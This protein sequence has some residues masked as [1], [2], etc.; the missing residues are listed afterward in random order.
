MGPLYHPVE[1]NLIR[2]ILNVFIAD[3]SLS[4]WWNETFHR[5][6][7]L[8]VLKC[9]WMYITYMTKFIRGDKY[10]FLIVLF[11]H[12]ELQTL[13]NVES[14]LTFYWLVKNKQTLNYNQSILNT[15]LFI[16]LIIFRILIKGWVFF[17]WSIYEDGWETIFKLYRY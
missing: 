12:G 5:L 15:R 1:L 4:Y 8:H 2:K 9:L 17:F 7:Q 10:Y 6:K 3:S 14:S 13:T 16:I 11:N